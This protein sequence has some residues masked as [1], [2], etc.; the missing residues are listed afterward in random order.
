MV[1]IGCQQLLRHLLALSLS[2]FRSCDL[3]VQVQW[4]VSC[5]TFRHDLTS[6]SELFTFCVESIEVIRARAL[7]VMN[8]VEFFVYTSHI[9]CVVNHLRDELQ[10][11]TLR[12][13]EHI[14]GVL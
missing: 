6:K 13:R 2:V 9:G 5:K 12:M 1:F 11:G 10:V 4:C 14:E 3:R 7:R 8:Q